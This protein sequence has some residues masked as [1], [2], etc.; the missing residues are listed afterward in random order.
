MSRMTGVR[1]YAVFFIYDRREV[2][3]QRSEWEI[4]NRSLAEQRVS[5]PRAPRQSAARRRV[6]HTCVTLGVRLRVKLNCVKKT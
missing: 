1:C 6:N 4:S 2:S 5:L 3:D